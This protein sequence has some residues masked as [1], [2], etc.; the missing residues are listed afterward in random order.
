M[1]VDALPIGNPVKGFEYSEC[2]AQFFDEVS[3]S[4]IV[5]ESAIEKFIQHADD[6]H[7]STGGVIQIKRRAVA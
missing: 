3:E 4:G 2:A 5:L 1:K 6:E 7:Q